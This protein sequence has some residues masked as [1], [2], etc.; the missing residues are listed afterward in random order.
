[1]RLRPILLLTL[2]SFRGVAEADQ[3][4]F[5]DALQ[6]AW[7][8]W[9]WA[10]VNLTNAAPAHGGTKSIS[11]TPDAWEA[12]YLHH[13]AFDS[14]PFTNL[15][16]WIHGGNTGGQRLQVQGLLSGSAQTAVNI[17]PLAANTW[18]QVTLSLA[19]LGVANQPNLDGFWIQDRTGTSQPTFYVD[20]V[21]LIAGPAPPPTTNSTVIV[22]VDAGSSRHSINP[23]IYGVAFA[24]SADLNDLN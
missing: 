18:Q 13:P 9:S 6:N 1:M 3:S 5:D 20:D 11:V 17:G 7:E 2:I 14:S 8:N 21:S 23:E 16:F 15:T 4:I 12:I 10:A 24:S 22:R 19:A